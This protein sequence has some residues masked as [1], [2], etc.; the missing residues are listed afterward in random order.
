MRIKNE[1]HIVKRMWS[2]IRV[3]KRDEMCVSVRMC[4]RNAARICVWEIKWESEREWN[5]EWAW[6]CEWECGADVSACA[7][8]RIWRSE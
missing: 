3:Y 4:E 8:R 6:E 1:E 5:C 2:Q 7:V